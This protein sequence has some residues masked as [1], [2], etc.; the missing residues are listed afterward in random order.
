MALKFLSILFFIIHFATH[1]EKV[2]YSAKTP[3]DWKVHPSG[4]P[5]G[6]KPGPTLSGKTRLADSES[7]IE[8]KWTD[9]DGD[10]VSVQCSKYFHINVDTSVAVVE[11]D[12]NNR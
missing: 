11:T 2:F 8:L 5:R 1:R 10:Q 3:E 9:K 12:S 7:R 6:L 4:R